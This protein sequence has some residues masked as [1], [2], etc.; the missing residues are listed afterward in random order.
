MISEAAAGYQARRDEQREDSRR[1]ILDAAVDCLIEGGFA[2]AT[3]L[4]IQTRAGIS[5]GGLLHH[6]PSRGALLVAASEHLARQRLASTKEQAEQIARAHPA[7]PE[8]LTRMVELMWSSFHEPH[9]WAALELWTASRTHEDIAAAL[10]PVERHLGAIVRDTTDAMFGPVY[11][12]HPR[13]R[14]LRELLLNSMRGLAL[15]YAFDRRDPAQDQNLGA[16]KDLVIAMLE[17]HD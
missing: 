13:Y 17:T 5:R 10:R 2:N 1:R 8:R 16:W 12:S 14:Q 6:F 7:G 11:V 4:R 3:T 15:T 9:W